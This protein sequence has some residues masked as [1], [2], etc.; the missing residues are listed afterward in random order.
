M[1]HL[2]RLDDAAERGSPTW[3]LWSAIPKLGKFRRYSKHCNRT[4]R[5]ILD[6]QQN[7]KIG[8]A[9][10]YRVP[11]HGL[12][13]R[14]QSPNRTTDDLQHFGGRRLLLQRLSKM[15]SRFDELVCSLLELLLE[16]SYSG[17]ATAYR[18]CLLVALELRRLTA[19]RLH[20]YAARRCGGLA[21]R[22]AN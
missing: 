7:S 1:D 16:V 10:A 4:P 2:L 9:D 18:R 6:S 11:Q 15:L 3:S 8:T 19:A 20:S 14:L 5:T 12:E 21:S 13:H 17:T 22:H